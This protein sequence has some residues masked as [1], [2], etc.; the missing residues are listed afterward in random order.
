MCEADLGFTPVGHGVEM[1]EADLGFTPVGHGVEMC[2]ADL[3]FTPVGH[4]VEMSEVR[5]VLRATL[6]GRDAWLVGGTVRDRALER[7]TADLDVVID[8]DPAETARSLARAAGRAA[9]FALS[10][11]FGAWRVVARDGSWQIDVERMRGESLHDDL[12][13]RDFTVNAIAEPIAGGAP[14]D[15]LGGLADLRER[16]LRMAA[17]QAFAAD[18]LRVLRLVRIAVELDF[19][20]E[21]HTL[22]AA[23]EAA[24]R[25]AE[26]SGERVFME[27]R[28]IVDARRALAGLELMGELGA[29]A[30]VLPELEALR[31]VEQ[32]RYHHRDVYGHTIEVLERTMALQ[33]DPTA[34]L[35][36]GGPEV[37]GTGPGFAAGGPGDAAHGPEVGGDEPGFVASGLGDAA[38]LEVAALLA[39]PLADGLTRGS[40]LRWGALLHDIAK[41]ATRAVVPL[42]GRV[43]FMG[44]DS[45]GAELAREALGR[46][47]TSE[48]LR[49]HVAALVRHH[50]RL[51]F[52]V[53]EPQPLARESVFGYLRACEPVEVDVTLLSVADR[54]ATRGA[55]A[56]ESIDAHLRLARAMLADALYWRAQ[57]GRP[58]PPLWRGDELAHE[59]G[60][61]LG[62][63]VGE[64][65]E[66]LARAQY[67][68]KVQ[69]K[70]QALDFARTRLATRMRS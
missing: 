25:L 48:R 22:R 54:L 26:I 40:A 70:A 59:L 13:L 50:L 63:H 1:C 51:G 8:G 43:T 58:Q 57:E 52:M 7:S 15:P 6:A 27:L 5:D 10:E 60:I 21:P 46:L 68:G 34:I 53:H 28:R 37:G 33:E 32:S 41:P 36:G 61:P 18:P 29:T 19:E 47:R 2:E 35:G 11:D 12:A 39:E 17:P 64:L 56:R 14:I 65:L 9:S 67:A 30:A 55:K 38:S 49:A 4:G 44:H 42:T 66:A 24:G 31:G 20:V 62:P 23:R 3:G 45:L 16:R 69:T